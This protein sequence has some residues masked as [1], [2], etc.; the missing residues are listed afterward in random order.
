MGEGGG[1]QLP[2]S[3]LCMP[4]CK[5]IPSVIPL[6]LLTVIITEGR[7]LIFNIFG[8]FSPI[9]KSSMEAVMAAAGENR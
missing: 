3:L 6:F 9:S 7:R 4:I 1:L 2:Y 5:W 8:N